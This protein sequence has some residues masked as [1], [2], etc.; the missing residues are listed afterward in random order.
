MFKNFKYSYLKIKKILYSKYGQIKVNIGKENIEKLIKKKKSNYL[1]K[2]NECIINDCNDEF[3][4]NEYH[5]QECLEKLGDLAEY[6]KNYLEFFCRP[7]F[8]NFHFNHIIENY[9]DVKAQLFYNENYGNEGKEN[10]RKNN[11]NILIFNET[12]RKSI[13]NPIQSTLNLDSGGN[14]S[15]SSQI[16]NEEEFLTSQTQKNYINDIINI[17]DK[18]IIKPNN[19]ETTN[20]ENSFRISSKGLFNIYKKNNKNGNILIKTRENSSNEEKS[21]LNQFK[22]LKSYVSNFNIRS[23]KYFGV[24][25]QDNSIKNQSVKNTIKLNSYKNI[26]ISTLLDSKKNNF[27]KKTK[28]SFSLNNNKNNSYNIISTFMNNYLEQNK[29]K[30][31]KKKIN[32]SNSYKDYSSK[33]SIDSKNIKNIKYIKLK[34]NNNIIQ[35]LNIHYISNNFILSKKLKKQ[36]FSNQSLE[37]LSKNLKNINHIII[38][39]NLGNNIY[40]NKNNNSL[41]N[42]IRKSR[43]KSDE[44]LKK[45]N[46]EEK[47]FRYIKVNNIKNKKFHF[48]SPNFYNMKNL[49]SI[50]NNDNRR[51]NNKKT[52]KNIY[53]NRLDVS[54]KKKIVFNPIYDNKF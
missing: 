10:K 27:N 49:K 26:N 11:N 35:P 24:F 6:Y 51:I 38:N 53:S 16:I 39:S 23:K 44:T 32:S 5:L 13:E 15:C 52:E 8:T 29:Y 34:G 48:H 37:N 28:K 17:M 46:D 12:I 33:N 3:L 22:K 20:N 54:N 19:Y 25:N 30:L 43:N 9:Y 14:D 41:S 36:I 1:A 50:I 2:Y 7:F 31:I 18:K 42:L 4:K 21:K 45:I 40:N 47:N